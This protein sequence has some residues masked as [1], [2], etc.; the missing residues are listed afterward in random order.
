MAKRQRAFP[1]CTKHGDCFALNRDGRCVSLSDNDFGRG[2]CP[3]Y[4]PDTEADMDGIRA[5]CRAYAQ[6][7]GGCGK[8]DG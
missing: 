7:H 6:S 8:E 1:P 2:D 5:A 4:K 3:F